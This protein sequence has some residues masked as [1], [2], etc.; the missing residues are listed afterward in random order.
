MHGK[1]WKGQNGALVAAIIWT[2]CAVLW[3]AQLIARIQTA[4]QGLVMLT[5]FVTAL[6]L[7]NAIIYWRRYVTLRNK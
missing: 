7:I 1:F 4:D 5:L 6:S 2:L 3:G